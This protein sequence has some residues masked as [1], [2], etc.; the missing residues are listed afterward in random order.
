MTQAK[1]D[2]NFFFTAYRLP[3]TQLPGF[4]CSKLPYKKDAIVFE[5]GERAAPFYGGTKSTD[6]T[7]PSVTS[8]T[9][10]FYVHGMV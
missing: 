2:A 4:R 10:Y 6:A 9:Y 7:I 5:S 8:G 3:A 1:T